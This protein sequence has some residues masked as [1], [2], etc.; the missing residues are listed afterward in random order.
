MWATTRWDGFARK[1]HSS[2]GVQIHVFQRMMAATARFEAR[3]AVALI[4]ES[5]VADFAEAMKE[6]AR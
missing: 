1:P 6:Q 2:T 5:P 3:G 4:L